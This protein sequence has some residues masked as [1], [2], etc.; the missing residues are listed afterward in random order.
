[1]HRGHKLGRPSR[2]EHEELLKPK[3][4]LE[5]STGDHWRKKNDV[6]GRVGSH[7]R[8]K[9]Y[10]LQCPEFDC[11]NIQKRKEFLLPH[12]RQIFWTLWA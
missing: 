3:S 12:R 2:I 7:A 8:V 10:Q 11:L 6:R 1:M 9:N 4:K 5:V